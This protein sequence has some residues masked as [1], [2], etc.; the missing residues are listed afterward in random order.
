[1]NTQNTPPPPSNPPSVPPQVQY[2][3]ASYPQPSEDD[4]LNLLDLWRV[5]VRYKLMIIVITSLATAI[6]VTVALTMTPIYRAEVLLA[7]VSDDEQGSMGAIASQFGGIASL[8]GINL[9]SGGGSTEQAL[10]TLTSRRF[11]NDFIAEKKLMPVLF[12]DKWDAASKSWMVKSPADEPTVGLAYE[13]FKNTL[14]VSSDKKSGLVTLAV[15]WQDAD[16]AASWANELV[17]RLNNH[18]KQ[19]AIQETEQSL[20]YLREQLATT[21]VMEMQ[22]AIYRLIEAQTKKIMLA[23]VRDQFVFKVIDPAVVPEK[24]AKP[25]RRL[26]VSLGIV[27][28]LVGGIF[29]AF[30]V[31][32]IR[33]QSAEGAK[34]SA[35]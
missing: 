19:L 33:K 14:A 29:L 21:S 30:L 15:E 26:I 17:V 6:A 9:S 18:E 24:R 11:I 12:A 22:Q 31:S 35:K 1:M 23:N 25:N 3:L 10:A 34:E 32:A 27:V 16:Q 2:V 20:A 7:P 4:E 28:G 5:L 13:A 8:A